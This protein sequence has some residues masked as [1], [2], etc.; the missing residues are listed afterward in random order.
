MAGRADTIVPKEILEENDVAVVKIHIA[1]T[2]KGLDLDLF[3]D[4]PTWTH[5]DFYLKK[6]S[7]S[8]NVQEAFWKSRG[9]QDTP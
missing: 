2:Q 3:V 6:P 7:K 4:P 5:S 1:Q 9:V 8:T